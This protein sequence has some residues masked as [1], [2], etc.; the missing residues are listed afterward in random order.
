MAISQL[1]LVTIIGAKIELEE[2][3]IQLYKFQDFHPSEAPPLYE[4]FGLTQLKSRSLDLHIQCNSIIKELQEKRRYNFTP[5]IE[6]SNKVQVTATNWTDLTNR[7]MKMITRIKSKLACS[8]K[9]TSN[10]LS[11]LVIL[12][13]A[14]FV[15]SNVLTRI[16]FVHT[17]KYF[18]TIR[19][20]IPTK[21]EGRFKEYLHKWYCHL[22]PI[23]KGRIERIEVDEPSTTP[24]IPTRLENPKFMKMFENITLAQ[25]IPRYNEIDP[26]PLIAFI[27]P[28]FYGIMFADLGQGLVLAAFGSLLFLQRELK[29]RY[30]Y[31]GKMIIS[32][33]LS[34]SV[35]GLL[36][37]SFF[38]LE[39]SEYGINCC[40]LPL[41]DIRVFEP[42]DSGVGEINIDAVMTIIMIVIIIGTFH[43]SIAYVVAIL[44]N[45]R[46]KDYAEAFTFHLATLV[47]YSFGIL[48]AL[49]FVGAELE[50]N[51]LFT[52]TN[53]LPIFWTYFGIY[54]PSS[55]GAIISVPVIIA[56]FLTIVFG[57]ALA[58]LSDA[59]ARSRKTK[60]RLMLAQGITDVIF[61]PIVFLTNTISYARL[62]IFLII[63]SAL[64]GFVNTAWFY[65]IL[66]LPI[67]VLGNIAVI[68]MEGFLV[69]IQDFRLHLYEW[70]T[71][72]TEGVG[73]NTL[74]TPIK[75]ETELVDIVFNSENRDN[76]NTV[77]TRN[78]ADKKQIL[79]QD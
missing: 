65:G 1:S 44:D 6:K 48:F 62:G 28:F 4:E 31:W 40:P 42:S 43:L 71:K 70:L 69:Y 54:I 15:I 27:F 20:Y 29:R 5:F 47:M 19:G 51:Q 41:P 10:D 3:I 17:L 38:G 55:E 33:G 8:I 12:R 36:T 9:L 50:I 22:M 11:N 32:F 68:V 49:S 34:A 75:S 37:G 59:S 45:I 72:F 64:M 52:S 57:R 60:F 78:I 25:G 77:P 13:E 74:F 16:K 73:D 21:S 63:H 46:N 30:R 35:F 79:Y 7:A 76:G 24:I 39:L 61:I 2:L 14:T 67:I 53:P 18:V 58:S 26:T 23:R 56:S 66:G